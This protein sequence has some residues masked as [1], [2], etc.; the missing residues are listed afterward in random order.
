MIRTRT[1]VAVVLGT[2]LM[3]AVIAAPDDTPNPELDRATLTAEADKVERGD[4]ET[5]SITLQQFMD[6]SQKDRLELVAAISDAQG[7]PRDDLEHFVS[8]MGDFAP[9]KN[10]DLIFRDVFGWCE[11]E[12]ANNRERFTSHFNQLD[13]P[14]LSSEAAVVCQTLVDA[15]LK[16]PSTADHP[17]LDR[18]IFDHGELRYTVRS[19]VDAQN[20]FG[21]MTRTEYHC[22]VQYKGAGDSLDPSNWTLMMLEM[23]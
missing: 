12:R 15:S 7:Q 18:D 19:Y 22:E 14:D 20:S 6:L 21:A 11:T 8:C 5:F 13:A 10:P 17:W 23:S 1:K 16:A 2:I 3:A 4:T 9:S